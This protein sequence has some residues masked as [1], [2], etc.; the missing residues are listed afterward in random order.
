VT[1]HERMANETLFVSRIQ[2][3]VDFVKSHTAVDP[4]NIAIAGFG[5][6]GT[7]ALYY[8]L[9]GGD[10]GVKAITSFHGTLSRVA[11]V[12]ASALPFNYT[13]QI[14]I[15]SGGDADSMDDVILLENALISMAADYELSRY[16]GV[17]KAYTKWNDKEGRYNPHASVRSFEA[18][19]SVLREVFPAMPLKSLTE[20]PTESP[21]KSSTE[22]MLF[23]H[24]SFLILILSIHVFLS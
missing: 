15:E 16:S 4:A 9:T 23:S 19:A 2:A 17:G 10:G 5:I 8:A 21:I 12:A 3:A 24:K 22:S 13:P 6:G 1:G 18:M 14:L 7:G 20:S 11:T